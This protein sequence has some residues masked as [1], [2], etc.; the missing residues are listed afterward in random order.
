MIHFEDIL[1]FMKNKKGS[2]HCHLQYDQV[3]VGISFGFVDIVTDV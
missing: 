1:C 2:V 3:V